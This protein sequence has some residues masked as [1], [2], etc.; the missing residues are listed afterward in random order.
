MDELKKIHYWMT[1]DLNLQLQSTNRTDPSQFN[2]E[3]AKQSAY[4]G[5]PVQTD[6]LQNGVLRI[7][8]GSNQMIKIIEEGLNEAMRQERL[9]LEKITLITQLI[10]AKLLQ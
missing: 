2:T 8:L 9:I 4:L 3:I 7:A 5:Q 6:G 10:D 1:K